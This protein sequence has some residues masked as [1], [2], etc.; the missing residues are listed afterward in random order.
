VCCAQ[1]FRMSGG[2]FAA[3]AVTHTIPG[4]KKPDQLDNM[5]NNKRPGDQR[6]FRNQGR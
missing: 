2:R 3:G 5:L 1:A 6:P 4:L